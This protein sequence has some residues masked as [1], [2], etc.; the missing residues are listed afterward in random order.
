MLQ[1]LSDATL[2]FANYTPIKYNI[3]AI[4][5]TMTMTRNVQVK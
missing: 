4:A 5:R 1:T 2:I 3:I